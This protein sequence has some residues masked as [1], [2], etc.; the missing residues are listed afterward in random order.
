MLFAVWSCKEESVVFT[1]NGKCASGGIRES[2][3]GRGIS[4]RLKVP[5]QSFSH[6]MTSYRGGRRRRR[7]IDVLPCLSL[8]EQTLRPWNQIRKSLSRLEKSVAFCWL[9]AL[10]CTWLWNQS[11]LV[12]P[13]RATERVVVFL[14]PLESWNR[15]SQLWSHSPHRNNR[16]VDLTRT[17]WIFTC[18]RLWWEQG[19][20]EETNTL[21][22]GITC[23]GRPSTAGKLSHRHQGPSWSELALLAAGQQRCQG[24]SLSSACN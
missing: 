9:I 17:D 1:G 24:A 7:C 11:P 19:H 13:H 21:P 12:V 14:C 3:D 6:L 2:N 15:L 16:T 8:H 10:G 4:I 20:P 22:P 5:S 23:T 18:F